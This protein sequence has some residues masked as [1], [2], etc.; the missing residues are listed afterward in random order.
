M[1]VSPAMW[2]RFT[3]NG[4]FAGAWH[5]MTRLRCLPFTG[6]P[7][8]IE[9]FAWG[10]RRED[11]KGWDVTAVLGIPPIVTPELAVK[12]AIAV[13]A[14]SFR[15]EGVGRVAVINVPFGPKHMSRRSNSN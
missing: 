2:T 9:C 6:H 4:F 12:A 1:A 8:A 15:P 5:G 11:D 3:S 14:G 10:V 13:H 7:K